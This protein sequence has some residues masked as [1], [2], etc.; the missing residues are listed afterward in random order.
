MRK[1]AERAMDAL[2]DTLAAEIYPAATAADRAVVRDYVRD[3]VELMPDY[4]RLGFRGLAILFD[5]SSLPRSGARFHNLDHSDRSR[6]VAAWRESRVGF[7]RSMI[8]FYTTFTTFGLYSQ[9]QDDGGLE[10][11]KAAA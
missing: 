1:A 10:T 5:W 6:R 11:D 7:R 2:V 8:A 3:T 4:L 9:V